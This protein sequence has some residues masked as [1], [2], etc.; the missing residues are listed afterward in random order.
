MS[1][2]IPIDLSKF[3]RD[4]PVLNEK[5]LKPKNSFSNEILKKTSIL[6]YRKN[7][8]EFPILFRKCSLGVC[9]SGLFIMDSVMW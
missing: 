1:T 4:V 3:K 7:N 5:N 6:L 8:D 9:L 2:D